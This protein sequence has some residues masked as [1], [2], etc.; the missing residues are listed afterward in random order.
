MFSTKPYSPL[1]DDKI[2]DRFKLKQNADNILKCI[3][4]EKQVPYS[5]ENIV[6]KG[7]IAYFTLFFTATYLVRQIVALCGNRLN[8]D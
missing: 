2:L 7:E 8:F 5:V 4:S 6:R 1:P 3:Q